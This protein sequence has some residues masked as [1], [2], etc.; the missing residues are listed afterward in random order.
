[1]NT[2]PFFIHLFSYLTTV[3]NPNYMTDQWLGDQQPMSW[4][5]QERNRFFPHPMYCLGIC[6]ETEQ[7]TTKPSDTRVGVLL[8]ASQKC[9]SLQPNFPLLLIGY[10]QGLNPDPSLIILLYIRLVSNKHWPM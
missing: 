3:R 6:P 10:V 2:V 5:R 1:M 8:N 9:N 7:T 4:K